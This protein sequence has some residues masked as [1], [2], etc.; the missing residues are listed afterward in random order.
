MIAGARECLDSDRK[1]VHV[2]RN[3][4]DDA[5]EKLSNETSKLAGR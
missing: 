3:Q 5:K 2:R 4:L 1:W